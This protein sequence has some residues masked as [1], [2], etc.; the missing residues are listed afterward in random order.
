M[1][2]N[3]KPL[4]LNGFLAGYA[5]AMVTYCVTEMITT[6]NQWLDR[7]LHHDCSMNWWRMVITTYQNRSQSKSIYF[8]SYFT[9]FSSIHNYSTSREVG[10]PYQ[11]LV[12]IMRDGPFFPAVPVQGF[13]TN[14]RKTLPRVKTYTCSVAEQEILVYN[15]DTLRGG[16]PVFNIQ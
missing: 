10:Y 4:K 6:V 2:L 11:R 13:L 15:T 7:F 3:Y 12:W 14:F 8:L 16:T 1:F 9:R 5:V